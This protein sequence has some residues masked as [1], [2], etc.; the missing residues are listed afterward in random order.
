MNDNADTNR[1][2]TPI[3][4]SEGL[5]AAEGHLKRLCDSSFL[6]LWSYPNIYCDKDHKEVCDL[7]VVF[8]E[9]IIIFSDK[10]CLFPNTGDLA[11]DWN[12]WFK[13]AIDKS[14][15]Q[16]WG[17]ERRIKDYPG[18]LFLEAHCTQPFPIELPDLEKAKFHRIL[19]AHGASERCSEVLGGSG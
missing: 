14:A 16:L 2:V 6:S 15:R 19:I 7:L 3:Q 17:A 1:N 9:H 5:T 12:R 10:D 18:R 11:L 13:K 4:K 8:Q